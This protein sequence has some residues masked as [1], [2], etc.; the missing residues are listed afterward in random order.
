MS[1]PLTNI[2]RSTALARHAT[3]A[4]SFCSTALI[5]LDYLGLKSVAIYH[6]NIKIDYRTYNYFRFISD[7]NGPYCAL[8]YR[9]N[10]VEIEDFYES[11]ICS[12]NEL[13]TQLRQ[14]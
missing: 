12:L 10:N 5:E 6:K 9:K 14:C 1:A 7:Y 3:I 2:L 8:E 4:F 11:E 13:N